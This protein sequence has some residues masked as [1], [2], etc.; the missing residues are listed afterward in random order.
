MWYHPGTARRLAD[1]LQIPAAKLQ[2]V[3]CNDVRQAWVGNN[4]AMEGITHERE[5]DTHTDCWGIEWVKAG[6]FNQILRSPLQ[7]ADEETILRYEHPYE[8]IGDLLEAMEPVQ[9]HARDFFVGCDVSPC[10]FE[11]VSRIRGMEEAIL[12]LAAQPGLASRML[13]DSAAFQRRLA[14]EACERFALDW[15]WTGDDVAG[16]EGMMMNPRLW[17]DQVRPHLE[18]I[19]RIGKRRG[20]WVAYHCCGSLL[21]II[22]DLVEMGIDVLNP[23]QSNCPGMDAG[24]LKK[25]FGSDLSFMGGVDTQHLLPDGSA[26]EVFRETRRLIDV[27]SADGGGYIL[28]ASHTVPPETPLENIV[29]MYA[30]AGVTEEE[31]R[32]R[33]ADVRRQAQGRGL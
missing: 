25:E 17:R 30:A 4:Y 16:Q 6:H 23:I 2:E 8:C 11:M 19:V 18:E 27:M 29:A 12:D 13:S 7:D 21:P 3:M 22:P 5:G 15:L 33:A 14:T 20:L 31:I 26:A 10:L 28:A 1:H 24:N 32:D 9:K